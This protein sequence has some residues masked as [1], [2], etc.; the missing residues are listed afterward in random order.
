MQ[1]TTFLSMTEYQPSAGKQDRF[2]L[3]DDVIHKF[4]SLAY[5]AL[6]NMRHKTRTTTN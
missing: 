3:C 2:F 5:F 6:I 4:N 1:T